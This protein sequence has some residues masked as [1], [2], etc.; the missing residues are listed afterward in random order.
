MNIED[1]AEWDDVTIRLFLIG[2]LVEKKPSNTR[3]DTIINMAD[4]YF[5]Y[6]KTGYESAEIIKLEIL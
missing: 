4:E 1:M 3:Y 2:L 5:H 6:I